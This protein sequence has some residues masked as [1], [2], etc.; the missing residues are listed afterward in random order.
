MAPSDA[1]PR[2]GIQA[3]AALQFEV[4]QF[5]YYEAALLDDRKYIQGLEANASNNTEVHSPG[6]IQMVVEERFP[7]S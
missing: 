2:D 6:Y 7:C 4:E 5:L 3:R 1:M